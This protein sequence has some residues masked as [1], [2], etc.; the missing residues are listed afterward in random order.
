MKKAKRVEFGYVVK[1]PSS[2]EYLDD[3]RHLTSI[4]SAEQFFTQQD[5][6][7][8]RDMI[9]YRTAFKGLVVVKVRTTTEE[10]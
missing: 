6:E 3:D 9:A 10:V 5:A 8:F 4:E 7:N 2:G 1:D